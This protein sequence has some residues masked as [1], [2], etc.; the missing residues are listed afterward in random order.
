MPALGFPLGA[1]I[2]TG[3]SSSGGAITP[4]VASVYLTS[5]LEPTP[6]DFGSDILVFSDL[7]ESMTPVADGRVLGEAIGRR[8]ITDRGT[9]PFHEDSYGR[10]VR[11][12][13]NEAMTVERLFEMKSQMEQEARGDE[14]VLGASI[15]LSFNPRENSL[16]A[17]TALE[18]EEG[19]YEF[20]LIVSQLDVKLL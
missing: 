11:L 16:T 9:M 2:G 7:D 8:F 4:P 20:T 10:D 18:T 3:A 17:R 13:L 19:P 15:E 6:Q 14:R 5:S 1:G 12:W